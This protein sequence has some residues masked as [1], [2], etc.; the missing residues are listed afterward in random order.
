M[1]WPKVNA[2][3]MD[4]EARGLEMTTNPDTQILEIAR[5]LT[6]SKGYFPTNFDVLEEY[7]RRY[8]RINPRDWLCSYLRMQRDGRIV[9]SKINNRL[10][11]IKPT[12]TE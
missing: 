1:S 7:R 11:V 12:R 4:L 2:T 5:E 3:L 8:G 9:I 10:N 6:A